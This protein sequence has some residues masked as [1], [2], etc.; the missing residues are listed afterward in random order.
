[1]TK[2]QEGFKAFFDTKGL[3]LPDPVPAHGQVSGGGWTV[4][5]VSGQDANGEL[6]VDFFAQNR[7]TNSRHVR[8][9][10]DGKA[11]SL[12]NYQE[13]LIFDSETGEDWGKA[14]AKQEAHNRKVTEILEAKGLI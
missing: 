5:Y 1:M 4:K 8:I 2:V 11:K 14:A 6:Y 3:E 12:E 13:A 7:K 9:G 10:T